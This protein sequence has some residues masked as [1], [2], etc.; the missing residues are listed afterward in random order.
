MESELAF[1]E[2]RQNKCRSNLKFFSDFDGYADFTH[3]PKFQLDNTSNVYTIGSCFARNIERHLKEQKIPFLSGVPN[4]PGEYFKIGGMD[5]TG[6]QNVYTPGSVFEMSRLI[7]RTDENHSIVESGGLFYDLL[8]HGLNGQELATVKTIRKG[9]LNTYNKLKETQILIITLGYTEAWY[10]KPDKSWVNQ[11]PAEPKLRKLA[12]DFSFE[13]LDEIK[14]YKLLCD[15]I[16]NFKCI[17]PNLRFI[18]TVSPVP[19]TSTFTRDHIA[20]ANQRSKSIL[21]CVSQRLWRTF[22]NV[23]YFPS[24]EF[25]TLSNRNLAFKEDNIHVKQEMVSK[26]MDRFFKSYYI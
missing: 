14:V 23:D 24:Y 3:V 20:I 18:F 2:A 21:H 7:A 15:A 22:D 8:T 26:V 17:N 6:Y 12:K 11:S 25:V 13:M 1:N 16:E 4:V 19:L 10:Y 9:L 5:R